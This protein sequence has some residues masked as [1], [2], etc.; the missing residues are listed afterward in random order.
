MTARSFAL[1]VDIG[2]TFTDVVLIESDGTVHVGKGLSTP[3]AFEQGIERLLTAM[4]ARLGL[5]AQDCTALV[6]GTTV[7]TNAIIE[8]KG[9]ATGLITTRGFRDVLELRRVRVPRLYDLT[10]EKPVPLVER[11]LRG[12]VAERVAH[13][14]SVLVELDEASVRTELARLRSWGV[15]SIAVCLINAYANPVHEERVRDLIRAEAPQIDVSISSQILREMREYERTSTTVINA[16]V[17][18]VVQRYVSSLVRSLEAHGFRASLT[19]MQSTGGVMTAGVACEQPIH[20]IESGPAAGVVAAQE[21]AR[22]TGQPNA[23][24][25]DIGGTTAKASLIERGRVAYAA[26]YE[27]G[28]GFSRSGALTRGDGYALRAPTIDIS[29]IGAGGG[30]IVWVDAGGALRV[31]PRSAGADPGPACYGRGGEEPTLTD[32]CLLLGYLDPAGL[33]GGTVPL[34]AARARTAL[35]ER[36]ARLLGMDVTELAHGVYR[37]AVSTMTR[38][39]R[40]VSTERGK[41]PRDF[42]LIAFGGN[43]G[44]FAAAIARELELPAVIVPPASGIFSAF[45]LLY[46]GH[47][48]HLTQTFLGR[49]DVVDPEQLEQRWVA[50]EERARATL[51]A[52]GYAPEHCRL[53]RMGALRYLSQT[54]ELPVPW[55]EG[56]TTRASLAD[57]AASFED[58][59]E[60]TYGHRSRDGMV[61]LVTLHLIAA[62]DDGKPRVPTALRFASEYAATE[63]RRRAYFG[64]GQGWVEARVLRRSSLAATPTP[65]PLIVQEFDATILVP[66]DCV[67]HRDERGNVVIR[68]VA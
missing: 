65:G 64:A 68:R 46:A 41:D 49:I 53:R 13:D 62:G 43:G 4:L 44:L 50:L 17:K 20:M 52:E 35:E 23:V 55:P 36:V 22:T 1:G 54:H 37:I 26:E 66:P 47:E 25:L 16:Y 32:A 8:R 58:E 29:E 21:L 15:D 61:E 28:G 7:A 38:A 18:P 19:M 67:A 40:S 10:W 3:A 24:A 42:T 33:A 39:I 30:S 9:A 59:H 51:H 45:G 57:L 5:R 14:G 56:P 12:E 11:H 48:H 27:V 6:H 31:G 60:R 2:G 63:G 34:D